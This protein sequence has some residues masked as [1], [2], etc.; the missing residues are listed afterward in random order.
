[1]DKNL[2]IRVKGNNPR[3]ADQKCTPDVL[4]FIVESIVH[5]N[6]DVFTR[7]D[8]WSS[9]IFNDYTVLTFGKPKANNL[10]ASNE[11][12]KFISQPLDL[13]AYAGVI[14]KDSKARPAIFT[15]IDNK[16]LEYI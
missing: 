10:N 13:L 4:C 6:K 14:S 15:I 9:K 11:Y 1:M 12:D 16:V 2:D 5:L 7:D 3:F 8:I